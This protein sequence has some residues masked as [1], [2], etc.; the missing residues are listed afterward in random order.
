MNKCV[1]ANSTH[2]GHE[3]VFEEHQITMKFRYTNVYLT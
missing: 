1:S 3:M 2:M